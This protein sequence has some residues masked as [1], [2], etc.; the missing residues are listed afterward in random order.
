IARHAPPN[1]WQGS[2][3]RDQ[4]PILGLVAHFMPAR[5]VAILLAPPGVAPGRL[6]MAIFAR[7]DPYIGPRRRDRE[8]TD[9]GQR[10][11]VAHQRAVGSEVAKRFAGRSSLDS[12]R[13][14]AHVAQ[15]GGAR[16]G[17]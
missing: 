17:S 4:A 9:P 6:D 16:R 14:V 8:A 1:A 2:P 10:C 15:A 12:G 5:V 7:A 11:P 13:R 3:E